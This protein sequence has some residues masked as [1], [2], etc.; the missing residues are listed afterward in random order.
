MDLNQIR[1]E[2]DD[3]DRRIFHDAQVGCG[4]LDHGAAV[5]AGLVYAGNGVVQAV[6]IARFQV[7]MALVVD[8]VQLAA[9]HQFYAKLLSRNNLEVDEIKRMAGTGD[10]RG[11]FRDAKE[12]YVLFGR[13]ADHLL[14]G[15]VGMAAHDRMGM[16]I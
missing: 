1:V 12:L 7:H 13:G 16:K 9:Q 2:I 8:D 15:I 4:V 5:V 14:H 11:M 3:V 10:A 6:Q